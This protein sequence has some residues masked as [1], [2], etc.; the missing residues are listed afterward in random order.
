MPTMRT[1]AD[2]VTRA[3]DP[4]GKQARGGC[5]HRPQRDDLRDHLVRVLD[6]VL[7]G[8]AGLNFVV[9]LGTHLQVTALQ[10]DARVPTRRG[11]PR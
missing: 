6:Q 1:P 11:I 10:V 2:V 7:P 4:A 3:D 5:F 8:Q 9:G